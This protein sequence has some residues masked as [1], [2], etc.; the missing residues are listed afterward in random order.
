M[1]FNNVFLGGCRLRFRIVQEFQ[2]HSQAAAVDGVGVNAEFC[3][4]LQAPPQSLA[5]ILMFQHARFLRH[6]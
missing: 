5:G 2:L 1:S 3:L 6:V 4:E